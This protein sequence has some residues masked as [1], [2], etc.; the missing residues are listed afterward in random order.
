M[1]KNLSKLFV[2][3]VSCC[4]LLAMDKQDVVARKLY[5]GASED[6]Y[7]DLV[8]YNDRVL[9]GDVKQLQLIL[10][11]AERTDALGGLQVSDIIPKSCS[12]P[13]DIL[14]HLNLMYQ[15][16]VLRDDL[17]NIKAL[18]AYSVD[19][20]EGNIHFVV[21]DI[22]TEVSD[23]ADELYRQFAQRCMLSGCHRL[24]VNVLSEDEQDF[25]TQRGYLPEGDNGL[26]VKSTN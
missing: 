25:Y 11:H 2:L 19:N 24:E 22:G 10:A 17:K 8:T 26:Y 5:L 13:K 1:G 18:L 23:V 14:D 3:M 20:K 21:N 7:E 9:L 12:D 6:G 16:V 15:F 4:N